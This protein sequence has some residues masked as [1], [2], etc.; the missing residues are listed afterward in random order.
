MS[1]PDR[2]IA[3]RVDGTFYHPSLVLIHRPFEKKRGQNLPRIS[4]RHL[5]DELLLEIFYF[6]RLGGEYE[7]NHRRRWYQLLRVC[8]KWR[9][10]LLESASRLKLCLLCDLKTPT[11]EMLQHSPPLP[12]IVHIERIYHDITQPSNNIT[13]ALQYPDRVVYISIDTWAIDRELLMALGKTFS[14]LETFS[15]LVGLFESPDRQ[16]LPFPENFAAPHLR[17][18]HLNNVSIFEVPSLLT[19]AAT[20]LVSLRIEQIEDFSYLSPDELVECIS[21]MPRLEKLSIRFF[22]SFCLADTEREFWDTQITCT[23]LSNLRELAFGG[24]SVYLEKMLA[25]ISTPLLQSFDVAFFSQPMLAIQHIS[26]FLSTIQDLDSRAVS[27]SFSDTVTITYRPAQTS[28]SLSCIRFGSDD[29][30]NRLNQQLATVTQIC[31]AVGP[32]LNTIEDVAL[33][34]GRCYVPDD[35]L[36]AVSSG[37]H[38]FD[39][40]RLLGRFG[41]TLPSSRSFRKS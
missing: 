4:I 35:F 13:H 40:L 9:Y 5:P 34:F 15:L 30:T 38:S 39:R 2:Q 19:S 3:L 10:L 31:A 14:A 8:R 37:V 27:V 18:L 6:L 25:L 22:A 21:S 41:R 33:K 1:L 28:D 26:E 16:F 7:W 24:D 32:A 29:E 11:A 20:T 17:T 36:S 23:V 12:L